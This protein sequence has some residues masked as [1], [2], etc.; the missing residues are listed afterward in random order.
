MNFSRERKYKLRKTRV[1][2]LLMLVLTLIISL[3]LLSLKEHKYSPK[4]EI[5]NNKI[6]PQI[7]E[8]IRDTYGETVITRNAAIMYTKNNNIY[9]QVG[10][11]SKNTKI[12]LTK[13]EKEKITDGYFNI[14]D[15]EYYIFYINIIKSEVKMDTRYKNYVPYNEL[16]ITNNEFSL[17]I[18]DNLVY[19]IDRGMNFNV[20]GKEEDFYY[21]QFNDVLCKIKKTDVK[22][23][24]VAN[25]SEAQVAT[26]IPVLNYHFFYDKTKESCNQ[27]I[28]LELNRLDA[29]FKYLKENG[30]Y[31]ITMKELDLWMDKKIQLPKKSV[32][33]TVDDGALG[34]DTHLINKLEEYDLQGTLFLITAWWSKEKYKSSNLEIQS[35]GDAIH[36]ENHCSGV[37][38]GAKG[39]C[40]TKEKLIEDFNKSKDKLDDP[41][42]FCYPYYLY[43][44]NMIEALKAT[45]FKLAFIGGNRKV[46]QSTNKLLIPRYVIYSSTDVNSLGNMLN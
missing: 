26:N 2:I 4:K 27:S 1:L 6:T 7:L 10:I 23:L 33:I 42:A 5:E 46:N 16:I 29:H 22:E 11:V 37:S 21:V 41:I 3:L 40:L 30:Y 24:K 20:I 35:H 25:N 9:N 28:C 39:L 8:L 17:Y 36:F 14:A 44:N 18:D 32:L 43:N 19:S 15:T 34:T 38:R 31:T 45:N 12:N 13:I